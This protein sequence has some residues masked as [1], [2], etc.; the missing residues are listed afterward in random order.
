MEKAIVF[1]KNEYLINEELGKLSHLS[2]DENGIETKLTT[3]Y[4]SNLFSKPEAFTYA[5]SEGKLY[6]LDLPSP[7]KSLKAQGLSR[8]EYVANGRPPIF[9]KVHVGRILQTQHDMFEIFENKK[10]YTYKT[11]EL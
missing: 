6:S 9:Y 4:V 2:V 3:E 11:K 10:A 8:E 5:L 1:G 7:N